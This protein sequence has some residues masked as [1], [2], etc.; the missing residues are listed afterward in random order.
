M[1]LSAQYANADNTAAVMVTD[2]LGA[3]AVSQLE[4]PDVWN[5]LHAQLTPTPYVAPSLVP[6]S[7]TP[8]QARKALRIAGLKPA[9]EQFISTLSDEE[10]EDWEYCIEVKRTDPTI[11]KAAT[12][13]GLTDEHL[14]Q[15]FIG[16]SQLD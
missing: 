12:A 14:D 1:I 15:L 6:A 5:T 2:D 3:V 8:L 10:R 13:L 11:L 16:A 4:T 7:V 9:V